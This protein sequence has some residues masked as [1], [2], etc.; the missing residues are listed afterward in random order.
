MNYNKNKEPED[1]RQTDGCCFDTLEEAINF[2]NKIKLEKD[3]IEYKYIQ[4]NIYEDDELED[5]IDIDEYC[6]TLE[7]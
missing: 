7:I 5:V 2:Y 1:Y 3:D 6:E 4:Q